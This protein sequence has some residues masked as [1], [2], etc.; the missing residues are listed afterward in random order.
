V[1]RSLSV[2]LPVKNAQSTLVS[3]V[4]K[5]LDV[6][7]ELS[8]RIELLIIDDGSVDA[9]S[10]VAKDLTLHYPQVKA[11]CQ[12]RS[13]GLEAA[14]NTA[15]RHSRGD[16]SL[17]YEEELGT[18]LSD[19]VRALKSTKT[20]GRF[21]FRLDSAKITQK[22]PSTQQK[23]LAIDFEKTDHRHS[24]RPQTSSRPARPNFLERL[25]GIVFDE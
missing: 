17:I 2:L 18:P 3:T 16:I 21:Y 8:E 1:A 20:R 6:V 13:S 24:Q 23:R 11:I 15:L 9:T 19:I 12:S 4:Q 22:Q 7:S 14:I 25:K 5:I 10:E